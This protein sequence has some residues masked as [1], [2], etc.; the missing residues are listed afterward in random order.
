MIRAIEA[1][2]PPGV[3]VEIM[4][5]AEHHDEERFIPD[6]ELINLKHELDEIGGPRKTK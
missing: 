5:H 4:E 6:Q 2:T 1:S 3:T